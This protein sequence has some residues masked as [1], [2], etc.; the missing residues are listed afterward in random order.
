MLL[1]APTHAIERSIMVGDRW[2]DVDAGKRAGCRATVLLDYGYD[3][4]LRNEPDAR[5]G[6]LAEAVDWIL[7]HVGHA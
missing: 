2:R 7:E 1:Q 6:S 5:V 4:P 3:E